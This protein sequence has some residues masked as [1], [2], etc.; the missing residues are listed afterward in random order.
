MCIY[1]REVCTPSLLTHSHTLDLC[2]RGECTRSVPGV[3][4]VD[5]D[6]SVETSVVSRAAVW[7]V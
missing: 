5:I 6:Y 1:A 4:S 3:Y 2:V 7:G